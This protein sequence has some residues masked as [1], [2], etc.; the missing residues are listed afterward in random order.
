MSIHINMVDVHVKVV[1]K[2]SNTTRLY[3]N[4]IKL[5]FD[6]NDESISLTVP[7]SI[8]MVHVPSEIAVNRLYSLSKV[9]VDS[10]LWLMLNMYSLKYPS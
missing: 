5:L 7:G 3:D 8:K 9:H 6:G 4:S 10:F 2:M 1:S